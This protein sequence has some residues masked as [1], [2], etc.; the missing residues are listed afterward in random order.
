MDDL[1]V[2]LTR[3]GLEGFVVEKEA[4][5]IVVRG[6][7]DADNAARLCAKVFGVAYAAPAVYLPASMDIVTQS[8]VK[9]AIEA[10]KPGQS[11]AIRAHR[12]T[13]I[14]LSRH[15]IEINGGSRVLRS[16]GR[17]VVKVN[18]KTPDVTIFV[19]LVGDF[20]Y[21][22]CER[23]PGPGG[24]PLSSQWRMLAVLDSGPLSILAAYAMMRRGCL[25]EL[26]IPFSVTIPPFAKDQQLRLAQ[27]LREFVTR[28]PYRA[29]TFA[30]ES[31]ID[32]VSK[33]RPEYG[34]AKRFARLA[35]M[36][37]AAE[38]RYKGLVFSDVTG[39]LAALNRELV[40]TTKPV[41]PVFHPL[42]GLSKEDLLGMCR[43]IGIPDEEL[44]SQVALESH[45]A[46]SLNFDFA[47]APIDTE[48]EQ[49]SL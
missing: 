37:L 34:A 33:S 8:I 38:K 42:I 13:T 9:L 14:P 15:E 43:E 32:Q 49:I 7:R 10:L 45:G 23:L 21:V 12:A 18:L 1:R 20:A 26:L 48:F 29:F 16:L 4:G 6:T 22:Y 24:L 47:K 3:S 40:E 30:F 39:A 44:R 46:E 36:K 17:D 28:S 41:P 31:L 27:I 5:R 2:A 35:S 19:D 25:V 11:F